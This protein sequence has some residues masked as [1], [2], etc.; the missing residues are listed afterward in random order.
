MGSMIGP[1]S[2]VLLA[3]A[4]LTGLLA[5]FAWGRR[6]SG[7]TVR[8]AVHFFVAVTLYVGGYAMELSATNLEQVLF[9]VRVEYLG[10]AA[11]PVFV[12]CMVLAYT[13]R[14]RYLTRPV[15]G[16]LFAVPA[17]TLGLVLTLNPLYYTTL[18]L[19]TSGSFPRFA[20]V[21]GPWY[22]VAAC[23]TLG[24]E[25]FAFAVLAQY[26][27]SAHPPFRGQ[28]AVALAGTVIP[29]A[30]QACYLAGLSPISNLDIIA[31]AL[32][33]TAI[34]FA[35]G[36]VRYRLFDLAPVARSAVF[37]RI[38][39]GVLVFDGLGRVVEANP[40]ATA[41]IGAGGGPLVGRTLDEVARLLPSFPGL[42]VSG[43]PA[44]TEV[45]DVDRDRT[46]AVSAAPL[47][48]GANQDGGTVVLIGDITARRR[49]EEALAR[50]T[51]DL[52]AA[53]RRLSLVS[54]FTRHDLA[55]HLVVIRGYLCVLREDLHTPTAPDLIA[56]LDEA[57]E[58][59]G[60]LSEFIRDYPAIGV[61]PP[62][63]LELKATAERAARGIGSGD[64][65]VDNRLPSV[66]V[67]A[68]PLLERVFATLIENAV[69]HGGATKAVLG[70]APDGD[71]LVLAIEDDGVGI[72]WPDK[73]QI[74]ER[75]VGRNTGL[76][77]FLAREILESMGMTI[78]ETGVPGHGARF[79]IRI[80][81]GRV[82][83]RPETV[84]DGA[85]PV[86]ALQR[87]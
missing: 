16:A 68:D 11:A 62:V 81:G 13:G 79:E 39:I 72:P 30:A 78:A 1:L 40:S 58:R 24:A 47:A 63:W 61:Q 5:A 42:L 43:I 67:L 49:A 85:G 50:R 59:V 45:H 10:I 12:I 31:L 55:N 84:R 15:L 65:A 52:E 41:L 26:L 19:N 77:L 4:V 46:F 60:V 48:A 74:F 20:F 8:Y 82:R 17:I 3:S 56:R 75:G 70:A 69:R 25:V 23:F 53:N 18:G 32:P 29:I 54:T 80:P 87:P 73:E 28:V 6:S 33:A 71:D 37:D 36:V 51:A 27:R 21:P 38:P 2:L 57:V 7:P 35:I 34:A 83:Y 14:D 9:W 86:L 66:S 44:E 64:F 76:G 22:I